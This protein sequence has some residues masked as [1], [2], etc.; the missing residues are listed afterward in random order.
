MLDRSD[1]QYNAIVEFLKCER[2]AYLEGVIQKEEERNKF[3]KSKK[4]NKLMSKITTM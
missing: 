3:D 4:A 2:M 1:P